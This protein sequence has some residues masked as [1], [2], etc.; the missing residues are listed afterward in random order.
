MA[1]QKAMVGLAECCEKEMGCGQPGA[2]ET[3][4]EAQS[5][6]TENNN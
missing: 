5:K 1:R 4:Q 2:L 6:V 3:G